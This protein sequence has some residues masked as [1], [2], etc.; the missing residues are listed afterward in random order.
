MQELEKIYQNKHSN[1]KL[2]SKNTAGDKK[3]Y[4]MSLS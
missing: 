3:M 1:D 2:E 4:C